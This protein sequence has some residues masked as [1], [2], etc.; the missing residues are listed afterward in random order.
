MS[1]I[2][3]KEQAPDRL[4]LSLGNAT[5][6]YWSSEPRIDASRGWAFMFSSVTS[7]S[8]RKQ[9]SGNNFDSWR[10]TLVLI[11]ISITGG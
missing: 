7:L 3:C 10:R 8:A 6:R 2:F 11:L 4:K 1:S 9:S 5:H